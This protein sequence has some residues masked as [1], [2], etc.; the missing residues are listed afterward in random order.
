MI[1]KESQNTMIQWCICQLR[2]LNLSDKT[3]ALFIRTYHTSCPI[4]CILIM[5]FAS[6]LYNMLLLVFLIIIFIMFFVFEGCCLSKI[7]Y[8]L[9]NEDS[10]IIDPFLEMCK[11][12]LSNKNRMNISVLMA[13]LFLFFAFFIFYVRFGTFYLKRSV[14]DELNLFSTFFQK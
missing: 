7:E 11:L 1:S 6:Q 9:D 2:K 10:T 12:E 3:I 13:F 14:Y 5:F 8:A 4:N